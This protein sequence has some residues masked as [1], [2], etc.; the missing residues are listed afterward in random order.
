MLLYQGSMAG[1]GEW[2]RKG[3]WVVVLMVVW[4]EEDREYIA[5]VK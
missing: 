1:N 3:I 2:D 4:C 5:L